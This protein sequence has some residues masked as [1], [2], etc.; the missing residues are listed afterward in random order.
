MT[1]DSQFTVILEG[2]VVKVKEDG[3][4]VTLDYR[5]KGVHY[6][7]QS[8]TTRIVDV[9][10]YVAMVERLKEEGAS[11]DIIVAIQDV[12]R[13]DTRGTCILWIRIHSTIGYE[14]WM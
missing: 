9:E 1:F 12:F 2:R 5:E 13:E 8:L 11:D 3:G 6:I 10:K 7:N 14:W 4:K